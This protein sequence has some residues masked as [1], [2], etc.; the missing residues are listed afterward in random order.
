M[1]HSSEDIND[2]PQNFR[3]KKGFFARYLPPRDFLIRHE[4]DVRYFTLSTRMQAGILLAVLICCGWVLFSSAFFVRYDGVSNKQDE[5][6]AA[7][8][9]AYRGVLEDIAAYDDYVAQLAEELD[10][11]HSRMLALEGTLPEREDSLPVRKIEPFAVD[12]DET[13]E[14]KELKHLREERELL[15]ER[16][17]YVRE[18]LSRITDGTPLSDL[19][20]DDGAVSFKTALLQRDLAT[21]ETEELKQRVRDLEGM[22]EEMQDTQ[23]LAFQKMAALADGNIGAIEDGLSDISET[24]KTAGLGMNSLLNRIR[25]DKK[26]SGMGGPFIPAAM[27]KVPNSNLN[28]SLASL[29]TRLDR[30]SE[31]TALQNALP[32]GKPIRRIRVTS[33]FGAREDPFQGMPARHEAVDLRGITGEPVYTRAPGKVVRAGMWGWYGN[34]VEIDHGMGIRTRYAHLDK[35]FVR[36][37]ETVRAGDRIGSVGSTGRSTGSHLHYE[38]RVRGYAVD[39]MNFIK[40]KKN[41]F[42]SS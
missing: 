25:R 6:I 42:Q 5:R 23:I 32:L 38:I 13:E 36:R 22:I 27:P 35:I 1:P 14:T 28:I 2:M 40:A 39:P 30:W 12:K 33:P 41:V 15:K 7:L 21:S 10:E 26:T 11:N 16:L 31:L 19:R 37:G 9:A 34:M 17:S 18:R 4:D 24:L 8:N 29:N 3:K 20:P